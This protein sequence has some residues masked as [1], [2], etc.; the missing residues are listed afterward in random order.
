MPLITRSLLK[1]CIQ[2]HAQFM[3]ERWRDKLWLCVT[4]IP[5]LPAAITHKRIHAGTS[6]M[7]RFRQRRSVSR[8]P[9]NRRKHTV[10][11]R[12]LRFAKEKSRW[13]FEPEAQARA[14]I[15][16]RLISRKRA[17]SRYNAHANCTTRCTTIYA[18]IYRSRD[19]WHK[20][21]D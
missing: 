10:C 6:I 9:A 7:V 19:R 13:S 12:H 15:P 21:I 2:K 14:N 3:C 18:T 11:N 4:F 20:K 17:Y 5:L 8:N 1:I 16:R